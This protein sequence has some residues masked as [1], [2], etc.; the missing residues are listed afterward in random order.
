MKNSIFLSFAVAIFSTASVQLTRGDVLAD[1]TFE[2]N[3]LS[4]NYSPGANTTTTNFFAELGLQAG[5]AAATG[6][7]VG[8]A[9]YSSPAGDGSAKS[10]SS[11][12]WAVG[13]YYQFALSAANYSNLGITFEQ[14][15]SGTGP[16]SFGLQYSVDGTT[17]NPFASY[18]VT[19]AP[20][21]SPTVAASPLTNSFS[22]DLS[23]ITALNNDATVAFRLVDLNNT[24]DAAGTAVVGTGG[25]DRVDD[26]IVN[27]ISTVPEPSQLILATL[28]GAACLIALRRKR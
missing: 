25:T 19:N 24:V 12:L 9:V 2:T 4:G 20:G 13:D 1:W 17:F 8:S 11:T 27:G 16:A 6:L 21:F 26:F 14:V 7:H 15:S 18:T 5:T 10:L 22:F 23:S 3:A 28:G